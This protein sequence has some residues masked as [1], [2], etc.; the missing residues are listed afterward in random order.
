MA[1]RLWFLAATSAC[2]FKSMAPQE[3]S[4]KLLETPRWCKIFPQNN[5][6]WKDIMGFPHDLRIQTLHQVRIVC[7]KTLKLMVHH[8]WS[9]CFKLDLKDHSRDIFTQPTRGAL[10]SLG[11]SQKFPGIM[12]CFSFLPWESLRWSDQPFTNLRSAE[13]TSTPS[14]TESVGDFNM[15]KLARLRMRTLACSSANAAFNRSS[16]STTCL[17][18]KD[19]YWLA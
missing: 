4:K 5:R 18:T 10:K 11:F 12:S 7:Q 14:S 2:H 3:L 9:I 13:E 15:A 8:G 1:S 17:S 16:S 19:P 6:G